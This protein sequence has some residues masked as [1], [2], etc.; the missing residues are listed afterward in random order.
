MALS[1]THFAIFDDLRSE[2]AFDTSLQSLTAAIE[3]RH[4]R[5]PWATRYGIITFKGR[6][7]VPEASPLLPAVHGVGHEG[8]QKTLHRLHSDFHVLNARVVV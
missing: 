7:Y 4:Q 2:V 8:V 6:I 5:G 3:A 1:A